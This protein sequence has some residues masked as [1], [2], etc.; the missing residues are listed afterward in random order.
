MFKDNLTSIEGISIYPIISLLI[1]FIFF[2][3]MF[4]WII[5]TNKKQLEI[6][7]QLPLDDSKPIHQNSTSND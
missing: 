6:I 3:G 4:T 2:I 7:S 5:R 1:F